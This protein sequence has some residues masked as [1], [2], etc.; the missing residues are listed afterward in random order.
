M[1]LNPPPDNPSNEMDTALSA[2]AEWLTNTM[3]GDS[4][5]TGSGTSFLT[6]IADLQ[7]RSFA[8]ASRAMGE[9]LIGH[10]AIANLVFEHRMLVLR[11]GSSQIM[12]TPEA[13]AVAERQHTGIRAMQTICCGEL[14]RI[15]VQRVM[16]SS[17]SAHPA[18]SAHRD[19]SKDH[20]GDA[21]S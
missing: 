13:A 16:Y 14:P 1:S 8:D 6:A 17:P 11:S 20:S 5:V 12:R 10:T 19:H 18:P 21:A 15:E 4:N 7:R 3:A 9:L 2:Y